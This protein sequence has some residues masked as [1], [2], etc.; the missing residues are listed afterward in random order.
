MKY[1]LIL[2]LAAFFATVYLARAEVLP[3]PEK[4]VETAFGGRNGAFV[5]IDCSSQAVSAFHPEMVAEKLPPCSTFKIWNTLIGFENGVISSPEDSFYKWNGKIYSRP[6]WN[7]DMTLKEA[8]RVSCVPAF[9]NLARKIGP[10]KMQLWLDKIKYGDCNTS[11]GIDVFW[12][13]EKGRK[14]LLISPAEQAELICSLVNGKLPF[15]EKSRAALK[16]LMAAKKTVNGAF[17]GKT[18]SGDDDNG[19]FNLGWFVGYVESGG[20]TYA[21]ACV[22]KGSALTGMD[23]R[24]I[25]ETVLEKHGLL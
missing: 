4:S 6:E 14:P 20:R 1:V 24:R 13:P 7:K 12:L 17:Y 23:A 3:I 10:E 21:F 16:E 22:V 5:I 25:V 8:F 9:Q 18:G 19:K 2:I 15:S 11:A